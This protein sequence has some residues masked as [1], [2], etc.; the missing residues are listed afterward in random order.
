M[1]NINCDTIARAGM[2]ASHAP[3]RG[4][5][6]HGHEG[7]VVTGPSS[8]FGWLYGARSPQGRDTASLQARGLVETSA[9]VWPADTAHPIKEIHHG[10]T[11]HVAIQYR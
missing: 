9:L 5:M 1:S 7:M 2:F 8:E 10:Y 11:D 3:G 4:P 6:K